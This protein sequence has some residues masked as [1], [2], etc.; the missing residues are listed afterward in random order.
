M[1]SR[2]K[3]CLALDFSTGTEAIEWVGQTSDVFGVYKVGLELFCAEGPHFIDRVRSA[4][5]DEIF[6]DLKLHDIPRTVER[7]IRR[8]GTLGVDYLTIHSGGGPAMLK[9]A[10]EAAAS[11]GIRPLAVTVLTS[12]N[13]ADLE[14]IGCG[15]APIEVV[16]DRARLC[17]MNGVSGLVC[18]AQETLGLRAAL[19]EDAFLVTPGIRLGRDDTGDQKRVCT[20]AQALENGS[21]MLVIG[22]AVTGANNSE[23]ALAALNA[24]IAP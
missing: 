22:R 7:A 5:A 2:K 24:A 17:V 21:S 20:P 8:L 14:A 18:S 10:A 12:L 6:L 15:K 3:L 23:A 11:V 9:A 19:T 1:N 4:G 16:I 13:Q